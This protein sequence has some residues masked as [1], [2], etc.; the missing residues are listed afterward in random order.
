MPSE[1]QLRKDICEIGRRIWTR[2]FVA[3][4]DG[5]ISVRLNDNQ[6]LA[7]PTGV[8][9]GF[10]TPDM[11][12]KV[13]KEGNKISGSLK[14]S[15]E[16]KMHLAVYEMR[17]DVQA[18]VHAHPP[19]ATG[20]AVAG[21]PIY[22]PIMPE[23]V[24]SLG[25]IPVARYGTPSTEELPSAVKDHLGCHDAVLLENHGALTV[26]TDLFNAYFKMETIELAAQISMVAR[27]LGGEREITPE[28]V[29]KLL[30][31][32]KKLGVQGRHPALSEDCAA[33]PLV[34]E[35]GRLVDTHPNAAA[36]AVDNDSL[37]QLITL[38]TKEVLNAVQ[39]GNRQA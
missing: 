35:A 27:L 15:S 21:M 2:G 5:N 31:V 32:R 36:P 11:I 29:E 20:Y 17:P 4:N 26:G 6:L 28:N 34:D 23:V 10:M 18:V 30:N 16:I 3:A 13:D 12:I 24:I 8:S 33:C 9:K 25:W 39:G 37:V 7:T 22:R 19:T 1:Y 38:V 14:P